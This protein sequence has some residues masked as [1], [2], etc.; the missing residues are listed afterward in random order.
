MGFMLKW[1]LEQT[2]IAQWYQLRCNTQTLHSA[3][4]QCI[5]VF[6]LVLTINGDLVF[7]ADT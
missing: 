5:Y 6:C 4:A 3:P 1:I 7:V 2:C